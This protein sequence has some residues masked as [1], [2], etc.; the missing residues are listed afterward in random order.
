[1]E[2]LRTKMIIYYIILPKIVFSSRPKLFFL[3]DSA[4]P[5]H[6]FFFYPDPKVFIDIFEE[7]SNIFVNILSKNQS[8]VNFNV[9][10]NVARQYKQCRNP[11]ML[12]KVS[13]LHYSLLEVKI[14]K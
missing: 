2:H 12:I 1:M 4:N 9:Q 8:I 13:K 14:N 10:F 5:T 11:L 3:L 7:K 6:P